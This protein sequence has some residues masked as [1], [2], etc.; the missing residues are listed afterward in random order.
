MEISHT[1]S[2]EIDSVM[3]I[4]DNARLFMKKRKP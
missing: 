4:Y 3:D 2:E 1:T